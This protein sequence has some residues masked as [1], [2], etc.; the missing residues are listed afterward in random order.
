[1][2]IVLF[3]VHPKAE[4]F[5]DYLGQAKLLKPELE[6]IDGFIDNIRYG[7]LRRPGWILSLSTWRDEKA[8]VRWRTHALHHE[9]QERG[10]FEIF[11]DYHLRV[12]QVVSDTH[13]PPGQH[14]REQR[15]DETET[16]EARAISIVEMQRPVDM[17]ANASPEQ[18]AGWLG[19]RDGAMGLVSWDLFDAILTPGKLLLMLAWREAARED[20]ASVPPEVR[21]RRVRVIRDYGMFRREEAPQYYREVAP[22]PLAEGP[23]GA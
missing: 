20:L 18:I 14:L 5:D 12:G 16:G 15:L 2:F 6:Q 9:V 4:K 8:L 7:S 10:R 22:G 11:S 3:E 17:P 1:M 19:L 23:G 21:H 13:V